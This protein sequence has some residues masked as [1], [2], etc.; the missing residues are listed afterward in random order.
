MSDGLRT[1][2]IANGLGGLGS[3]EKMTNG[4]THGPHPTVDGLQQTLQT[5]VQNGFVGRVRPAHFRNPTDN[6]AEAEKW[7]RRHKAWPGLKGKQLQEA[8]DRAVKD[9]L[10]DWYDVR[11]DASHLLHVL[12][13][14]EKRSRPWT[15]EPNHRKGATQSNGSAAAHEDDG[16]ESGP[17]SLPYLEVWE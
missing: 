1:G 15:D 13:D 14:G 7:V 6:K 11:I 17:E 3:S 2:I 16:E 8:F 5:L 9:T 10:D 12:S 4:D